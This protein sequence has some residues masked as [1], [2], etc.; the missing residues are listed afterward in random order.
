MSR[1]PTTGPTTDERAKMPATKPM[2]LPRSAGGK[3]SPIE[4]NE[5]AITTPPPSP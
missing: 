3:R 2:Y 1:P 4:I 5:L